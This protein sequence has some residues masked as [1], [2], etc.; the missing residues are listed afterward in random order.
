MPVRRAFMAAVVLLLAFASCS[1]PNSLDGSVAEAFDLAFSSVQIRRSPKAIA[2]S[3]LRSHGNEVVINL[4]VDLEGL[5][6]T[7]GGDVNLAESPQPGHQRAA[8]SR[9]VD[10]EP[11]RAMPRLSRGT[12]SLDHD[13]TPGFESAG[14]FSLAFVES[15]GDM[16]GGRTLV[17][18][19]D[20]TVEGTS[21]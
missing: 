18:T 21:Y 7:H 4:T 14:N 17:G 8:V 2:I 15:D 6:M 11:V 20:A 3:Y 10:N 5:D 1:S 9:A 19:F 12:L 13:P 16:G